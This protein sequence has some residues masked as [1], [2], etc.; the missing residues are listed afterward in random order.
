MPLS[1]MA[2]RTPLPVVASQGPCGR[3]AG[4]SERRNLRSG[5]RP[6]PAVSCNR[7]RKLRR[8]A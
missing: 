8:P 7:C 2:M 5:E 4:N 6:I 3:A 1:R